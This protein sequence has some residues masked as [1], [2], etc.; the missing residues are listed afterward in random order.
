VLQWT[1]CI[2]GRYTFGLRFVT[3]LYYIKHVGSYTAFFIEQKE[4]PEDK[5]M[6]SDIACKSYM[7]IKIKTVPTLKI[8]TV[9]NVGVKSTENIEI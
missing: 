5:N 3:L 8:D 1:F 2:A 7:Q 4:K 6:L 9:V